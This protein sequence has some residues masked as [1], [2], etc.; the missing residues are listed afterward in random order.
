MWMCGSK[1]RQKSKL[2]SVDIWI[3]TENETGEH[4]HVIDVIKLVL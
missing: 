1:N 4:F 2:K 3:A